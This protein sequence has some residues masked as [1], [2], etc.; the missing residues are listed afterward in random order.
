[1]TENVGADRSARSR[2]YLFLGASEA[3]NAMTEP[4]R[5]RREHHNGGHPP[6]LAVAKGGSYADHRGRR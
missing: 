6:L 4:D 5:P 2:L 1:M 3:V